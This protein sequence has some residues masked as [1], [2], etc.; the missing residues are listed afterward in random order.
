MRFIILN[1]FVGIRLM[2]LFAQ[3]L[4]TWNLHKWKVF[5]SISIQKLVV[6]GENFTRA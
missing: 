4:S 2:M 5:Q 6:F 3:E 1:S